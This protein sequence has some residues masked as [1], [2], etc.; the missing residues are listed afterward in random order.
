MM[1]SLDTKKGNAVGGLTGGMAGGCR[2]RGAGG[3]YGGNGH[4]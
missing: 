2:F 3:I 4:A 1:G